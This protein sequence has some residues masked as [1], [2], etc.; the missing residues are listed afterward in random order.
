KRLGVEICWQGFSDQGVYDV[1]FNPIWTGAPD[2][3]QTVI[4]DYKRYANEP[5][6][7]SVAAKLSHALQLHLAQSLPDYMVPSAIMVLPSWPLTSNGKIDRRALPEPEH[8]LN[9]TQENASRSPMEEI[10]EGIWCDVLK[11]DRVDIEASFFNLGGHSLLATHLVFRIRAALGTEVP[12]AWLFTDPTVRKLAARLEAE[13]RQVEGLKA[14]PLTAQPRTGYTPLSFA[15]QRLW[16][17]AQLHPDNPFYN[18]T[19]AVRLLGNLRTA[20]LEQALQELVS[21]HEVLRAHFVVKDGAPMQAIGSGA[22]FGLLQEDLSAWESDDRDQEALRRLRAAA[23][24]PYDLQSSPLFRARL[25]RLG[26]QEHILLLGMHHIA[27]DGWSVGVLV[28]ELVALYGA[29]IREEASPLPP[30]A[31]QYSDFACWQR[32]WLQGKVL[33][34]HLAYWRKKLRGMPATLK[35]PTD[36]PRS[37]T[38]FHAQVKTFEISPEVSQLLNMLGREQC[39]T[40]FMVMLAAFKVLLHYHVR[41]EDVFVG[42]NVANRSCYET[43]VLIGCFLN[44]LVLRTDLSGDPTLIELIAY[45]RTTVLEAHLH[46]DLPFEQLVADLQPR[47]TTETSPLFNVKFE[48]SPG[49]W[50]IPRFAGLESS[51]VDLKLVFPR[52]DLHL[53][54]DAITPKV[55]GKLVYDAELFTERRIALMLEQYAAILSLIAMQPEMRLAEAVASLDADARKEK[56][57]AAKK[58]TDRERDRLGSIRR[59]A[60]ALAVDGD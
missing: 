30:L 22:E 40:P 25:L 23:Q 7:P 48:C 59:K 28:R 43:G 45:V 47:R 29:F 15:Q 8:A 17:L 52:H 39:F 14:P 24:Q 54:V 20:A 18:I 3:E 53:Y 49:L 37:G 36:Y 41:E 21:R 42:S 11:L 57:L 44:Q 46:Q 58:L 38:E 12:L 35:L 16:F 60:V 6:H 33:E 4:Q 32:E 9:G 26:G 27:S 56:V 1:I 10:L 51:L 31:V 5:M 19:G 55:S 13:R 34:N 50:E 2:P